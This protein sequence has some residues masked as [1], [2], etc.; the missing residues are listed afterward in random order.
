[1]QQKSQNDG[2]GFPLGRIRQI[3]HH[4]LQ[5]LSLL[6]KLE[7]A[8][9]DIKLENILCGKV[10]GVKLADFGISCTIPDMSTYIQSRWYRAPEVILH[11][12]WGVPID[13]WSLGCV[14]AE[15]YTGFPLF[16]GEDASQQLMLQMELLGSI[17][18]S[19]RNKIGNFRL[20]R[21]FHGVDLKEPSCTEDG[22]GC[23]HP[24]G[25]K[26]IDDLLGAEVEESFAA[27]ILR[28]LD[29]DP[30]TRLT[31]EEALAHPFMREYVQ[32][33]DIFWLWMQGFLQEEAIAL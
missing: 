25:S 8:H 1:M 18:Q 31:P 9:A 22:Q 20:M 16:P 28:C 33:Q 2:R 6:K 24:V 3:S 10:G 23:P 29:L 26:N 5:A 30:D 19:V 21:F 14:L 15:L 17:P 7:I 13:M 32:H 11:A 12:N 4:L 27:F